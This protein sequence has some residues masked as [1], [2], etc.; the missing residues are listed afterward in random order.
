MAK[1]RRP[2]SQGWRTFISN[3]AEGIA[4]LDLFVVPTLSFQ[5]LFGLLILRHDRREILWLGVTAHPTAKWIAQQV[6]E[7]IGWEKP[8]K[9]LLR[10]RDRVYGNAFISRIRAMG[11]RDRP[12][13]ARSPW[14]NGY[15]ERAIGSIRRDCLDPRDCFGR[16]PPSPSA[17]LLCELL[18]SEPNTPVLEQGCADEATSSYPREHRSEARPR[19]PASS[20]RSYLISERD[21]TENLIR[22]D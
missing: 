6:T 7:A 17:A 13:A 4:A 15:C 16:A 21:S 3:H 22:I 20:L 9:Y 18:Q 10:D 14:Q 12:T 8:P 2:P 5:L 1:E 19:R 11:I